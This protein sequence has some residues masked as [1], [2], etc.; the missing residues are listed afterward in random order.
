MPPEPEVFDESESVGRI[1]YIDA[2]DSFSKNI[3]DL[4][5]TSLNVVVTVDKIDDG[6]PEDRQKY[7]TSFDAVVAGPGP[8]T[9]S[10]PKD[11]GTMNDL[12]EV[13]DI[14]VLGICLGFQ[15]LCLKNRARIGRLPAPRHGRVVDFMHSGTDIFE[16]LPESFGVTLYHSLQPNLGHPVESSGDFSDREL[17]WAPSDKCPDLVPLAWF[18]DDKSPKKANLMAVRHRER[19]FWGVQFHPESCK[20]DEACITLVKNWWD[21]VAA[22][23]SKSGRKVDR[24]ALGVV[25][26]PLLKN[27]PMPA[28]RDMLQFCQ[29]STRTSTYRTLD[30]CNL[31]TEKICELVDVPNSPSVVLDSDSRYS[32]ISV[33]SPG[34]WTFEY[35]LATRKARIERISGFYQGVNREFSSGCV[36]ELVR[37]VLS[38]KKVVDGPG[39]IPFWGGFMGYFSYEM[40]LVV[41]NTPTPPRDM[42]GEETSDVG[43]LWVERS[44]VVDHETQKVYIQSIRKHDEE[45]GEWLD[46]ITTRLAAFSIHNSTDRIMLNIAIAREHPKTEPKPEPYLFRLGQ[47]DAQLADM[48]VEGAQVVKPVRQDYKRKILKCQEYIRDGESYELCLT[49]QT[50]VTLPKREHIQETELRQWIL[51]K[52]LREF[53]PAAYGGY[54]RIGKAKIISSSPECFM[55]YNR[56]FQIDMKPMKGT[57]KKGNG[58]TLERA[59]QILDTPKEMGENLMIA[60]LIRHDMFNI[61]ASGGV[62]VHKLLEVEEHARVYQLITHVRGIPQDVPPAIKE[63]NSKPCKDSPHDYVPLLH[64]LPPGSMTGAPKRRSCELLRKIEG[65]KRS[66]Y[67][68]VMGYLDAGGAAGF[69]VLIRTAYSW[70]NDPEADEIWRIGAGGAV[71]SLSTHRG[72]WDEMN[73]KLDTVLG[74]FRSSSAKNGTYLPS[75]SMSTGTHPDRVCPNHDTNMKRN[76]ELLDKMREE[77]VKRF[78][79]L[80]G[81]SRAVMTFDCSAD[82]EEYKNCKANWNWDGDGD[83]EASGSTNGNGNANQHGHENLAGPSAG[84]AKKAKGKKR[85]RDGNEC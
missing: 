18:R 26:P 53:T 49:D 67:S 17:C 5:E 12:W 51:Y 85:N 24:G 82:S 81:N 20:S 9:P 33:P 1:L 41:Y 63:T 4:L 14:P 50:K 36:W 13:E 64:C 8:G 78:R 70:S 72:E 37:R 39:D 2:F 48:M 71:T 61:C 57:V 19:P 75:T 47:T 79:T 62:K 76:M 73:T 23:N 22:Y 68:G 30:L 29:D 28:E 7:L 45:N 59:K 80:P 11:V 27:R 44:I 66:I 74:I 15:S 40:G 55:L 21:A 54:L 58:M 3:I 6:W 25:E 83:G 52:R 31:T 69:S 32:I 43:L 56:K 10:N 35:S 46:L 38:K 42:D 84:K 60:D 77:Q 34:A 16:N 65:H